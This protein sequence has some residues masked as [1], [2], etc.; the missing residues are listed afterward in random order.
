[1]GKH[2]HRD[3]VVRLVIKRFPLFQP[4]QKE[5]RAGFKE[6]GGRED[7]KHAIEEKDY[8]RG[9]HI[10][11][12]QGD[13]IGHDQ[14]DQAEHRLNGKKTHRFIRL[15]FAVKQLDRIEPMNLKQ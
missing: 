3:E 5:C 7:D 9:K 1:M 15:F 14:A 10:V 13:G 12:E 11:G 2:R 4:A 6:N 8:Q